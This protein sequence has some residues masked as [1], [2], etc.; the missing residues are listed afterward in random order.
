M[1]IAPFRKGIL[2]CLAISAALLAI[3]TSCE[4]ARSGEAEA[5]ALALELLTLNGTVDGFDR[6]ISQMLQPSVQRLKQTGPEK[7]AA[8]ER[9]VTEAAGKIKSAWI[10]ELQAYLAKNLSENELMQLR[11]FY[12][13]AVGQKMLKVMSSQDKEIATINQKH[14]Q[15][16]M[17]LIAMAGAG[18]R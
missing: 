18:I 10:E 5:R 6:L 11:N 17:A 2:A 9:N 13:S 8:F 4:I 14:S 1:S 15:Q 16:L 12:R 3:F 7:A